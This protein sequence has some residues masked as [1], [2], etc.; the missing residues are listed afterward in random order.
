MFELFIC[1][2]AGIGAGIATGFAGLSAAVFISPMLVTFLDIPTFTAIGI[3]LASDV[4]ASAVSAVTYY[5]HGNIDVKKGFLLL[6]TVIVFTVIGSIA[7]YFF[8]FQSAGETIMSYW[9]VIMSLLL[10]IKFLVRP[11]SKA[12]DSEASPSRRQLLAALSGIYIGFICGFQGTGGGMMMLFALTIILCYGFISAVGTSVCVMTFTA[13]IGVASDFMINGAPDMKLLLPCV[14]FTL[15]GAQVSAH[16]A[17]KIQVVTCNRITGIL[18][19]ISGAI[20]L[21]MDLQGI[22]K[23]FKMVIVLRIILVAA[24]LLLCFFFA[25]HRGKKK[26]RPIRPAAARYKIQKDVLHKWVWAVARPLVAVFMRTKYHFTTDNMPKVDMPYLVVSN[27]TTEV[28]MF[29]AACAFPRHMYLVCGEHLRTRKYFPILDYFFYPITMYKGDSDFTAVKEMIRRLQ[30]GYNILLYPEGSRSFDGVTQQL[31]ASIGR[32]CKS[33]KCG[34][35]TYHTTGGYFA[36]PRW[37]YHPR[38]GHLEGKIQRV[39]TPEELATMTPQQIADC[40][41]RDIYEN[42]Y[43]TQRR[44]MDSYMCIGLAEGLENYLI[45][46]P[47]CGSYDSMISRDDK[48][49]CSCCDS[50]G[51]YTEQGFLAGPKIAFDNVYDWNLWQEERFLSDLSAVAPAQPMFTDNDVELYEILEDHSRHVFATGQLQGFSDH[52][53]LGQHYFDFSDIKEIALLYYGKTMLF[54]YGGR[55]LGMTGAKLHAIKYQWLHKAFLH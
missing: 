17:N 13:F 15:I 3:A 5:R 45:I 48:L 6:I 51:R 47:R 10:G 1:I 7:G 2:Q 33:A 50:E 12:Q 24:V 49:R 53:T 52:M 42:A 27:H 38:T 29:M 40:I 41:N 19:T 20:M 11:V 23:S 28:D 25:W 26:V 35:V 31:P 8:T 43:E 39:Y 14:L 22:E 32:L 46:C 44:L 34:L 55:H 37:A 36:E 30:S 21:L 18:L 54:T 4:L 9:T 16:I